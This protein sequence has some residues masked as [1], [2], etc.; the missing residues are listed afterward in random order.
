VVATWPLTAVRSTDPSR[1]LRRP[2]AQPCCTV[3]VIDDDRD[4][5]WPAAATHPRQLTL[6]LIE[7]LAAVLLRHGYP[8]LSGYALAE[9]T[10]S[11]YRIAQTRP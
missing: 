11:L 1:R 4:G 5:P 8:P 6:A 2:S 3:D 10:G 9:L 7:D